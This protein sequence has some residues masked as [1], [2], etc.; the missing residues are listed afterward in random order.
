MDEDL[1]LKL[2]YLKLHGLLNN[3][4]NYLTLLQKK[5]FSHVRFLKYII[6]EEYQIKKERARNARIKRAHIPELLA[7]ETFPFNKQSKLNKKKIIGLY[8]SFQYMEKQ[9]NV[10]FLGPTGIGKTGLA[11]SFLIQAINKGYSGRFVLFHDLIDSLYKSVADHSEE[12]IINKFLSYDCL[13]IDELGYIE[14]EPVQ[15]ALFFTLMQKR[16]R[17]KTTLITTNL[18]FAQWDSFLKNNQLTAALID[19]VTENSFVVNMKNCLSLR[20]KFNQ[21]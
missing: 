8:D 1:K 16:H 20:P 7:I 17:S 5:N 15:V 21:L 10:I 13:L 18:G 19:R 14:V 11:T 2:T 9:R 6:D 12:K 3:F 4:E